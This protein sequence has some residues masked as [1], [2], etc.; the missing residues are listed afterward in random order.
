M[1]FARLKYIKNVN[2][3]EGWAYS[4][5]PR[6]AYFRLNFKRGDKIN[7]KEHALNLPKGS[8][9][10]LSQKPPHRER[11]LTHV[12]EVV[13]ERSEDEPQ[14]EEGMWGIFRWVKIHWIA[15]F[16]HPSKNPLDDDVMKGKIPLDKEEMRVDWGWEN[17]LAKSLEG[18]KLMSKWKTIE[19]L[20][21]HLEEV[22]MKKYLSHG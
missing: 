8:L 22:F 6:W 21:T 7:V 2:D 20:R 1:D 5:N 10:I 3:E 19:N 16:G 15:D 4:D 14:Q 12:V 9:I 11:Y 18:E 17:T 13:N